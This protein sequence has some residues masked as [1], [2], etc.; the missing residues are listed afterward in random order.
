MGGDLCQRPRCWYF[1]NGFGLTGMKDGT[2]LVREGQNQYHAIFGTDG[3]ALFVSPSSLGPALIALG[4]TATVAGP[5][6]NTRKVELAEFFRAPRADDERET[7]VGPQEIL[8]EVIIPDRG[9]K[10][11]TYE[12][13]HR[14]GLDWPYVTASVAFYSSGGTAK[15]VQVVL[16]QVAAVPWVAREAGRA[17]EDARVDATSAARAGDAAV[18]GAQPLT[19]NGYKSAMVKAAV[20]RAVLA[21]AGI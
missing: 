10:N 18:E 1:R 15:D 3:P 20:K 6:G 14:K 16:G 21:A 7:V 8:T 2:S 17:M 9:K 19:R 5:E 11:A 13:R 12:V 4:A